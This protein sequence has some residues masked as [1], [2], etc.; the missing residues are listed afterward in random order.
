MKKN[1]ELLAAAASAYGA[2]STLRG[3]RQRFKQFTYGAQW[4]D[5]VR[6]HDGTWS[7]EGEVA[8][9][10]GRVPLTNN[11]IRRLVKNIVGH[12]RT[13]MPEIDVELRAV[14][15]S[16]RLEELDS[17]ML[18]EFLISGCAIQRV[19]CERRGAG[20]G[21]W[22]DNIDPRRFFVDRMSDPRSTDVEMVG[23]IRDM[24]MAELLMRYSGGSRSRASAI[25]RL[26]AS[27]MPTSF[28]GLLTTPVG[29]ESEGGFDFYR[30]EAGRCRVIEVWTLD[31]KERYRCHD[32]LAATAF[33]IEP[34]RVSALERLNSRRRR[35]GQPEVA[36]RWEIG[37]CWRCRVLAPTGEVLYEADSSLPG[38]SHPFV[39][40]FYPLTDGEVH[41]FVEDVIDQQKY[42]NRLI[43]LIDNIMSS[44]AKG[45]LLFPE[46]QLGTGLQWKDVAQMWSAYDGIIPYRPRSG[47]P[48]PQQ[49]VSPGG[50]A[51]ASELLKLE[52][53]LFEDVSGVAGVLQGRTDSGST[54][55]QLYEAQVRTASAAIQDL[56]AT[57]ADFR[58]ARNELLRNL[59]C[60]IGMQQA[61]VLQ[62]VQTP[63]V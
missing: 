57:F 42:V 36:M 47:V 3:R 59:V 43:T 60:A 27:E 48:A 41:S 24:S 5:A 52:M 10:N 17:R 31:A 62:S 40:K 13:D 29:N 54:S 7:T 18:E 8:A 26:Y 28:D 63:H 20:V 32:P 14:A 12:F 50:D 45:V 53:K 49:V 15:R 46:D 37:V 44:S 30:A 35:A 23:M 1:M 21:V 33:S 55:A 58:N 2:V 4:G 22:V 34:A 11:M 25:R 6:D 56:M 51:G 38:G 16:N 19:C 39:M 9:R 61:P